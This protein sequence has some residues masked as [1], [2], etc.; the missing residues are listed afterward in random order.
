MHMWSDLDIYL[1]ILK[2]LKQHTAGE[3]PICVYNNVKLPFFHSQLLITSSFHL[4]STRKYF[5]N[6]MNSGQCVRHIVVIYWQIFRRWSEEFWNA[7]EASYEDAEHT[8]QP[9]P[10]DLHCSEFKEGNLHTSCTF[11]KT[12]LNLW[13]KAAVCASLFGTK[14]FHKLSN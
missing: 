13:Y 3:M 6:E 11:L 12:Y 9:E 4:R 1:W 7:F 10:T 5:I 2:W 14:F 8:L